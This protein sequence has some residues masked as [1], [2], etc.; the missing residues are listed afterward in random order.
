MTS[1]ERVQ[2]LVAG[3]PIDRIPCHPFIIDHAAR[4]LGVEVSEYNLNAKTMADAQVATWNEYGHDWVGIGPILGIAEA[5]GSVVKY[6]R[7]NAPYFDSHVIRS[8]EDFAG[9]DIP[10]LS[11]PRIQCALEA[12]ERIAAAI[13]DRVPVFLLVRSPFSLA[14][15]LRG[16]EDLLRDVMYRPDFAHKILEFSLAATLAVIDRAAQFGITFATSD[17]VASGSLI[18]PSHYRDFAAPYEKRLIAR[19]NQLG[20]FPALLHICGNTSK[21]WPQMAETGAGFVSL[22]D[23]VDLQKASESIGDEVVVMGNVKPTNSMFLGTPEDVR[24]DARE[25]I[26]RAAK[27][28]KGFVLGVGCGLPIGTPRENVHALIDAAREFGQAS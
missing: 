16:T 28:R 7:D 21:I 5:L 3:R 23:V 11:H 24:I 17:P 12:I 15:N 8:P 6:P 26:A 22:D 4:V 27:S 13:G 19:M 20:R 25:C 14:S 9:I 1:L 10:S 18:S 2:A